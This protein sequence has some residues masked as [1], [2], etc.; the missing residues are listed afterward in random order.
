MTTWVVHRLLNSW[1]HAN[2]TS[3]GIFRALSRKINVPWVSMKHPGPFRAFSGLV[4]LCYISGQGLFL[5]LC[6][7][8]SQ[9][10][11]QAGLAVKQS[12]SQAGLA[13]GQILERFCWNSK[14]PKV[15]YTM[16][17]CPHMEIVNPTLPGRF[18]YL[19]SL[20]GGGTWLKNMKVL[21]S[22]FPLFFKLCEPNLVRG[23]NVQ[24]W[25]KCGKKM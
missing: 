12:N 5:G 25:C 19:H 4:G 3:L 9:D 22:I 17:T 7:L 18:W 2:N 20:G 14:G 23:N 11:S 8:K 21:P 1:L 10:P 13:A 6:I 16:L 24:K 15:R